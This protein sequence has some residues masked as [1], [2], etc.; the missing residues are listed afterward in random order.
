[1][2]DY[3]KKELLGILAQLE[4]ISDGLGVLLDSEEERAETSGGEDAET[5]CDALDEALDGGRIGRIVR[6]EPFGKKQHIGQRLL[7][8][9]V[10]FAR[11][12]EEPVGLPVRFHVLQ[13]LPLF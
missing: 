9:G 4:K 8:L 5:V 1:M 10:A 3:T 12:V 6:R 2:L 7:S 13:F 11:N